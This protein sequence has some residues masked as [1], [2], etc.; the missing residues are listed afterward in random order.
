MNNIK[1]LNVHCCELFVLSKGFFTNQNTKPKMHR[2]LRSRTVVAAKFFTP[3]KTSYG[4]F[5]RTAE[6]K[7]IN[8]ARFPTPAPWFLLGKKKRGKKNSCLKCF[9]GFEKTQKH[10]KL[11]LIIKYIRTC[12]TKTQAVHRSSSWFPWWNVQMSKFPPPF[13]WHS[14]SAAWTVRVVWP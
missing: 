7:E 12:F 9:F 1:T 2:P 11:K 14:P 3:D 5:F 4:A 13:W 10:K 6:L 8:E